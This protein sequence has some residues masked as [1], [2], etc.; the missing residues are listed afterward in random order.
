LLTLKGRPPFRLAGIEM[1]EKL[2]ELMISLK[3][4]TAHIADERLV[5]LQEGIK[6]ALSSVF[7]NYNLLRE[8]GGWLF[9]ISEILDPDLNK[10]RTGKQVKKELY[11]YLDELIDKSLENVA[12]SSFVSGMYKTT[13]NYE[14]GLFN[15]YDVPGLERTNNNL[16]SRFRGIIS[17][18]LSTTGQKGATRR[19][20]Q[21]SGAWELIPGYSN[22]DEL[23]DAVSKID[24]ENFKEERERVRKHR[25]RFK[26]HTR[27][28]KMARKK[29]QQLLEE[30][31]KLQKVEA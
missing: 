27:S 13:L 29:I 19:I 2:T 1:F 23:I 11:I 9:K 8:V 3:L 12:L 5:K 18:L 31:L 4:M 7:E 14:S 24:E 6:K 30:W 17:R 22:L 25:S 15:I 20:L 10:P 16:E 21:R 26:L 28:S